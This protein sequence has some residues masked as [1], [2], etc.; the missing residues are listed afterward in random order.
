MVLNDTLADA[1]SIIKNA[2]AVGK[3]SC[4]IKPASK[5][6]GSTLRVMKEYGYIE[7]FE[8][9]DDGKAGEFRVKLKGKINT[10]GVIRTGG[11][12]LAYVY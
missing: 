2:G 3:T 5:L 9:I 7:E 8:F 1:L 10:C 11:Q 4:T 12:L 6:I